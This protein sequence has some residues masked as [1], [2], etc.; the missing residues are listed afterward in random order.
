[1]SELKVFERARVQLEM[2]RRELA[3]IITS[4][5]NLGELAAGFINIQS[6]IEAMDRAIADERRQLDSSGDIGPSRR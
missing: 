4:G 1:M 5:D 3:G 2:K 6:A